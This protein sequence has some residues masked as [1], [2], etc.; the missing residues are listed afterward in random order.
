MSVEE[1]FNP[2]DEKTFIEFTTSH[3]N[4]GA[5]TKR[6]ISPEEYVSLV[7][8]QWRSCSTDQAYVIKLLIDPLVSDAASDFPEEWTASGRPLCGLIARINENGNLIDVFRKR[9][10]GVVLS[11]TG[12][13]Q[14]LTES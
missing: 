14:H 1:L 11:S 8:E 2:D 6:G 12:V 10:P 5:A 9:K 13:R 7:R 3:L 4:K